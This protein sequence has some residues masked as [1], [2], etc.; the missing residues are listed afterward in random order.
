M[1]AQQ[2]HNKLKNDEAYQWSRDNNSALN[3]AIVL[4]AHGF[5]TTIK[6]ISAMLKVVA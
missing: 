2:V 6:H 5:P 4:E 3:M 1:N